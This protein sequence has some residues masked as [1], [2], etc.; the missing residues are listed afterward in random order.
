MEFKQIKELMGAMERSGISKIVLKKEGDF[1][2][3]LERESR[4]DAERS[5]SLPLGTGFEGD[6]QR[7]PFAFSRPPDLPPT[8]NALSTTPSTSS[9]PA[10]ANSKFV[11][12]P[13]VGTFYSAPTPEDPTFVKIGDRVEPN[14]VV[15]IVEAMKVMNEVKAGVSGVITELFLN[16]GQ[17]VEFGTKIF[18]VT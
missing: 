17:P 16:N 15:C 4:N 10:D 8:S 7:S 18:R 13:M 6:F 3:Q 12:S 1:E 14:T 11:L 9:A 2:L 5:L